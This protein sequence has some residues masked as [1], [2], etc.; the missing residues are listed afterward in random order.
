MSRYQNTLLEDF[1]RRF[2]D[3]LEYK[4]GVEARKSESS[5]MNNPFRDDTDQADLWRK[6]W[7][8]EDEK[9]LLHLDMSKGN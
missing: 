1:I 6:G 7:V 3:K 8:E 2:R 5:I 4:M 9:I